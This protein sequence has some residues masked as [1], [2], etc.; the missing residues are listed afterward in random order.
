MKW[1]SRQILHD[2]TFPSHCQGMLHVQKPRIH[3]PIFCWKSAVKCS[4][5]E[6]QLKSAVWCSKVVSVYVHILCTPE[7]QQSIILWC[8]ECFLQQLEYHANNLKLFVIFSLSF[9]FFHMW[10][11]STLSKSQFK[12]DKSLSER[13]ERKW[14]KVCSSMPADGKLT[15]GLLPTA[16][17]MISLVR[18][19]VACCTPRLGSKSKPPTCG[20]SLE[21]KPPTCGASLAETWVAAHTVE[22]QHNSQAPTC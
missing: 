10:T 22:H 19:G 2:C 20:A 1:C 5:P 8:G 3:L 11:R 21:S 9:T 4:K 13:S 15:L 14:K 16:N 18:S 7:L 12:G 17:Q 6:V